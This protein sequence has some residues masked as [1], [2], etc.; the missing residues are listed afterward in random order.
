MSRIAL[1][2]AAAVADERAWGSF[3]GE[4]L[5]ELAFLEMTIDDAVNLRSQL[6]TL[7]HI[8]PTLWETCGR[9]DAAV[10]A[11]LDSSSAAVP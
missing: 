1:V 11:Y 7:L 3:L 2:A 9:A 4:W 8:D 6:H 5:T 10:E